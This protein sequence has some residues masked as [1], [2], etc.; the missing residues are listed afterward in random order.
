MCA[1]GDFGITLLGVRGDLGGAMNSMG[2]WNPDTLGELVDAALHA[3]C[4]GQRLLEQRDAPRHRPVR[5]Q[6]V[7]LM[8]DQVLAQADATDLKNLSA[9]A[10]IAADPAQG[11]MLIR[12]ANQPGDH[13]PVAA[14]AT[15]LPDGFAARY[16]HTVPQIIGLTLALTTAHFSENMGVVWTVD[17]TLGPAFTSVV[18]EQNRRSFPTIAALL[19][20]TR[21][22]VVRRAVVVHNSTDRIPY[23]VPLAIIVGDG[24]VNTLPIE[25]ASWLQHLHGDAGAMINTHLWVLPV[26]SPEL[27]PRKN[28]LSL[29]V[30]RYRG[31]GTRIRSRRSAPWT[32]T[33]HPTTSAA[34][35]GR[36]ATG[37]TRAWKWWPA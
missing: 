23:Q 18:P 5:R 14:G 3:A 26:E 35:C 22:E 10:D 33:P 34:E 15:S 31:R 25:H 8:T 28:P 1:L 6:A 19:I 30:A 20:A 36:S 4:A 29:W 17:G 12:L 2:Y 16:T 37:G 24:L 11:L 13:A 7:F 9:A 21:D 32:T 27:S